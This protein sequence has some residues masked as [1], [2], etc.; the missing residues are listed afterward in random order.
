MADH[1]EVLAADVMTVPVVSVPPGMRLDAL[2]EMMRAHS[3]GAV[4]VA[5]ASLRPLGIVTKT[6]LVQHREQAGRRVRL[7]AGDIMSRPLRTVDPETPVNAITEIFDGLG[8]THLPVVSRGRLVGIVCDE[9]LKHR[10]AT[11]GDLRSTPQSDEQLRASVF[12][13]ISRVEPSL[14]QLPDFSIDNGVVHFWGDAPPSDEELEAV[15]RAVRAAQ[16]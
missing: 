3:I 12:E 2:A 10:A 1:W 5:D 11:P 8:I 7:T 14:S 13:E 15:M 6:D 9:D 16:D 4:T